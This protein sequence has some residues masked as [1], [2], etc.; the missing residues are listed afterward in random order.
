MRNRISNSFVGLSSQPGLG[1]PAYF[2]RN[3]MYNI[4]YSPFKLYRG[5]SGDVAFHNTV[6]KCGDAL[7]IVP[8]RTVSWALFRNNLFIG[9]AGGGTDGGYNNGSGR[10]AQ[11]PDA[12]ATC[13]FNF[14][15]YGSIGTGTFFGNIAGNNF[16]SLS[17]MRS[18]T[19]ETRA[20]AVTMGIFAT[21]VEFPS[22]GPFPER[23]IP[24]LGIQ[25]DSAAA[26]R[27]EILPNVNDGY[28]GAAPD[29][30]AYEAGQSLPH[31]GPRTRDDVLPPKGLRI[32]H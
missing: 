18:D 10:V 8:G 20:I 3:V 11:V 2:I 30:G 12:D 21:A 15:G 22:S 14:D 13:D 5:S 9:G 7:M 31:Y 29:L 17:G 4:I 27:G 6:V 1:G 25:G 16:S 23:S 26:D 19:T 24:D 32:K 28:T